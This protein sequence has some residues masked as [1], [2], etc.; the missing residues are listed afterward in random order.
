MIPCNSEFHAYTLVSVW[1]VR[2]HETQSY[3]ESCVFHCT[4]FE[5]CSYLKLFYLWNLCKW[6][7]SLLKFQVHHYLLPLVWFENWCVPVIFI[8]LIC[9]YKQQLVMTSCKKLQKKLTYWKQ[10]LS[11]KKMNLTHIQK[12]RFTKPNWVLLKLRLHLLLS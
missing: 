4:H 2:K 11:W 7:C 3:R 9:S 8:E 12:V 6:G 5:L 10:P 1:W